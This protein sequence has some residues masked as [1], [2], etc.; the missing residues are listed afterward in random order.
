MDNEYR[1]PFRVVLHFSFVAQDRAVEPI[2][3]VRF[4]APAEVALH[5]PLAD[6]IPRRKL[7]LKFSKI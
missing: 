6:Q 3:A 4:G 1:A 7:T 5:Q 2:G